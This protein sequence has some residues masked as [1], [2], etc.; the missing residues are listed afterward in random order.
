MTTKR[1]RIVALLLE[2]A[3]KKHSEA[4]PDDT[5]CI[6]PYSPSPME[7]VVQ[8]WDRLRP[9]VSADDVVVE[10][11]CGDAR[12]IIH[13]VETC[14]VQA[15]GIEYDPNVAA[16]AVNQAILSI[17][18][19]NCPRQLLLQ[20]KPKT[21]IISVGFHMNGWTPVWSERFAGLMCYYYEL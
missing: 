5:V 19:F 13:G 14:G 3:K 8:V 1:Q 11:G 21:K 4:V 10:L 16:L 15:V 6:A 18:T 9:S 2:A 12:W 20:C 7:M 17:L